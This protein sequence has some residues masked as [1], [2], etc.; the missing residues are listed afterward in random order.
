MYRV[1]F[2]HQFKK[3]FRKIIK[4]GKSEDV[5]RDVI[6][7]IAAGKKL[8]LKYKDHQLEGNYKGFR[9]CHIET[10][11]LLIYMLNSKELILTAV[12]TGTHSELLKL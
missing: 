1:V 10:D 2:T 8:D 9:E 11:W 5:L 7:T 4:Q 6:S 12:R 3:D